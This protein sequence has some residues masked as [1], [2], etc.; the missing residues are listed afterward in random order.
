MNDIEKALYTLK[1]DYDLNNLYSEYYS[2]KR[3][4]DVAIAALEKQL[5]G[6]WI[7]ITEK[8]P[9]KYCEN[10]NLYNFQRVIATLENGCVC[11][12]WWTGTGF[13]LAERNKF[14]ELTNN[15]VIAWQTFPEPYKE[16]E[17]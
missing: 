5:N 8:L 17:Q 7:P 16:A 14:I 2:I 11:E 1:N 10:S 13:R 12:I 4:I 6:G 15:P 9:E 3:A